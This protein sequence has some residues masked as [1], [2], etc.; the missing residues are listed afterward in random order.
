MV[1]AQNTDKVVRK[2]LGEVWI[3]IRNVRHEINVFPK[4]NDVS[5]VCCGIL[6][7]DLV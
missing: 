5:I 4:R 3:A 1:F 6:E 2:L 7:K